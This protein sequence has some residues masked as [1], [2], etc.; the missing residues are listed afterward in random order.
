M[1]PIAVSRYTG[2]FKSVFGRQVPLLYD[3]RMLNEFKLWRVVRALFR[4]E[5]PRIKICRNIFPDCFAAGGNDRGYI[6][7]ETLGDYS[8]SVTITV[9]V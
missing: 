9:D 3:G 2:E 6:D 5:F 4:T 7:F 8:R 1:N